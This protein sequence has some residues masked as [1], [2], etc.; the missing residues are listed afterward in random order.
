[1]IH[2]K[3]GGC[4]EGYP[5]LDFCVTQKGTDMRMKKTIVIAVV[6]I[7]VLLTSTLVLTNNFTKGRITGR[8]YRV[9]NVW[10]EIWNLMVSEKHGTRTVLTTSTE[11]SYVDYD[12]GH[13]DHI[14][15]AVCDGCGVTLSFHHD[16]GLCIW[17]TETDGEQKTTTL[18]TYD[19]RSHT[20]YGKQEEAYLTDRL[21]SSYFSW[22]GKDSSFDLDDLGEYSFVMMEYPLSAFD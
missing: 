19:Y 7:A 4:P 6:V 17:L 15:I 12:L 9:E 11:Y 20:L 16:Y 22:A 14:Y 3:V 5:P 8:L 10:E 1:M 2:R 18:Y 21:L 13:F